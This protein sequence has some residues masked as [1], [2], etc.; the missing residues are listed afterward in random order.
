MIWYIESGDLKASVDAADA[1]D[2]FLQSVKQFDGD[3]GRIYRA[4]TKGF[5][6]EVRGDQPLWC[7]TEHSLRK[8]GL[9]ADEE[10]GNSANQ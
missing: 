7:S 1:E 3:L 10:V 5:I 6:G 8:A 2:A 4:S 9:M